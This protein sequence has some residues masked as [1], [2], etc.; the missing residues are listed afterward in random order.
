M[1][2]DLSKLQSATAERE[3]GQEPEFSEKST[4]MNQSGNEGP[5]EGGSKRQSME[6]TEGGQRKLLLVKQVESLPLPI[7][8]RISPTQGITK[9]STSENQT[10]DAGG[11]KRRLSISQRQL[12]AETGSPKRRR[13]DAQYSSRETEQDQQVSEKSEYSPAS[14]I[15]QP[16]DLDPNDLE[17]VHTSPVRH[18]QVQ[19]A[20]PGECKEL[21][22]LT[23]EEIIAIT[24]HYAQLP[25]EEYPQPCQQRARRNPPISDQAVSDRCLLCIIPQENYYTM[26]KW[27]ALVQIYNAASQKWK[28]S[29]RET[30]PIEHPHSSQPGGD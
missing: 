11:K 4:K 25:Q 27:E 12:P 19:E 10:G 3:G 18:T 14:R 22:A 7:K 21:N 20:V 1:K 15:T 6:E 23:V 17:S 29:T 8:K 28:H 24:T 16:K 9:G 30:V 13:M 2:Q 5:P 26:K